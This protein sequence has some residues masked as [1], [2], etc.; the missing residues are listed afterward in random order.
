MTV[1]SKQGLEELYD[2]G[3][4]MGL[5]LTSEPYASAKFIW[6]RIQ[7]EDLRRQAQAKFYEGAEVG[8]NQRL[9]NKEEK[10]EKKPSINTDLAA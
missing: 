8:H 1:I 4:K 7:D 9:L 10:N 2:L 3:V 6:S 5:D